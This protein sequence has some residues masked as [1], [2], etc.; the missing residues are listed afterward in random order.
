MNDPQQWVLRILPLRAF[1]D[2]KRVY[3]ESCEGGDTSAIINDP[4]V[5][6]VV[7]IELTGTLSSD[8]EEE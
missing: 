4:I 3:D 1:A 7:E 2:A 8:E 5:Q 6:Q